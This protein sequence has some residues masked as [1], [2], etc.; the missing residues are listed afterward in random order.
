MT[1]YT[2]ALNLYRKITLCGSET[3][4]PYSEERQKLLKNLKSEKGK[5]IASRL[6][7]PSYSIPP[8]VEEVEPIRELVRHPSKITLARTNLNCSWPS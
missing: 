8:K 4:Q 3:A 2:N 6:S 5:V 1:P 7:D